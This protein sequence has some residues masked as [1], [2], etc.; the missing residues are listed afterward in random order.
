MCRSCSLSGAPEA[1]SPAPSWEQGGKS[2]HVPHPPHPRFLD[3]LDQ[4]V[5]PGL[6][7]RTLGAPSPQ[8]LPRHPSPLLR[9]RHLLPGL[10]VPHLASSLPS[11]VTSLSSTS[12][13]W[14]I[15]RTT[16]P[17]H[18]GLGV[19]SVAARPCPFSFILPLCTL[20]IIPMRTRSLPGGP[21][22]KPCADPESVPSHRPFPWEA[23]WVWLWLLSPAPLSQLSGPGLPTS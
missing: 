18:V 23:A 16:H 2:L 1:G 12:R 14:Y 11:M 8:T 4:R 17:G 7:G 10:S 21:P 9:V 6:S 13:R 15:V 19:A 20:S 3:F 5:I 22:P